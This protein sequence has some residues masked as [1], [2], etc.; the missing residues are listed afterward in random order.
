MRRILRVIKN[1]VYVL[2][3]L[4][5]SSLYFVVTGLQFWITSYLNTIFD[6]KDG[7]IFLFFSVTC[8]SAPLLGVFLGIVLFNCVGGYNNPRSLV[9]CVIV[10]LLA[11]ISGMPVPFITHNSTLA[12]AFLWLVFF[13]GSIIL[14]PMVGIMLNQ[15]P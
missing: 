6:L 10:G 1:P 13:F 12:F 5:I 8:I 4:S 14:A 15:V 11:A 2:L 9:L 3:V 7:Q